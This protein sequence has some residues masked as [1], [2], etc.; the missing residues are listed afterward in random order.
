MRELKFRAWDDKWKNF[1][2]LELTGKMAVSEAL[3]VGKNKLFRN[4]DYSD[5]MQFT[6]LLDKNGTEI[7]EGDIVKYPKGYNHV[8]EM[9]VVKWEV[10][11]AGFNLS[12]YI[13]EFCVE[14]KEMVVV[15][16]V[17]ENSELLV[18]VGKK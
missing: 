17:Y 16:N 5:W 3:I 8:P 10:D 7:F 2:F 13:D 4:D 18:G 15:G 6:G 11:C 14:P 1:R 9:G 12:Y